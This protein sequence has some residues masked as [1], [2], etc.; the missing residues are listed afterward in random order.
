MSH[1]EGSKH[2]LVCP[3]CRSG[4]IELLTNSP[5]AG[6]GMS[7]RPEFR[8]VLRLQPERLPVLV[9]GPC[10]PPAQLSARVE[11]GPAASRS[12]RPP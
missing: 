1:S 8:Q 10:S 9:R 7:A 4:T 3:R 5:V 11:G 6:G 12:S 2:G